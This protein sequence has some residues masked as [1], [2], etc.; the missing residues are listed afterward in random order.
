MCADVES[1]REQRARERERERERE[2]TAEYATRE[3]LSFDMT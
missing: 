2:C 1:E 3:R